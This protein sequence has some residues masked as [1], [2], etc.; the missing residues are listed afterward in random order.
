MAVLAL[1]V[2]T[3]A[4]PVSGQDAKG[5]LILNT[6]GAD[7]PARFTFDSALAAALR[8][9]TDIKAVV[10]F[11]QL[12]VWDQYQSYIVG[13]ALIFIFQTALIAGLIV[14]RERRRRV[15][16]SLVNN[17][18]E[19]RRSYRGKSGSRRPLDRCSGSRANADRA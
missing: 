17:Q 18:A 15:E 9:S 1:M 12:S 13:A 14:Q 5:I 8:E 3:I 10:R 7:A 16:L 11:Q 6:Y 19:L 4:A 2:G